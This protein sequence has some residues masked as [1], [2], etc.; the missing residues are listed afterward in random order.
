MVVLAVREQMQT[1]EQ[2]VRLVLC[3]EES[4]SV[5]LVLTN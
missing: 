5:S 1:M 4:H 3:L 2:N